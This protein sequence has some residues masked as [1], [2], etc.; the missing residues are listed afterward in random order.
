MRF[1][2][3]SSNTEGIRYRYCK[4]FGIAENRWPLAEDTVHGRCTRHDIEPGTIFIGGILLV[5]RI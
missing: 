1:S 2:T 4:E 3:L 5:S